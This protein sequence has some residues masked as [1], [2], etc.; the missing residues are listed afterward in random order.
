MKSVWF[1]AWGEISSSTL[2]AVTWAIVLA[3]CAGWS[4]PSPVCLEGATLDRGECVGQQAV[5]HYLPFPE[6]YEARVTQ[7]Y[8]GYETHRDGVA[9]AVDFACDQGDPVVASRDGVVWSVRGDSTT[10]CPDESC[11]GEANYVIIDHGD[12]TFSTYYHLKHR[13]TFVEPGER[14]CQ[15][16]LIGQCGDTGFATG[17]HLHFSVVDARW[18]TI[19]VAFRELEDTTAGVPLPRE[20]YV[21]ENERAP[22]C[23]ETDYSKLSRQAF[24]HRGI[25]LDTEIP[26]VIKPGE[27]QS[28]QVKGRYSGS[29][30]HVAVMRREVGGDGDWMEQCGEVD[31]DGRFAFEIDWPGHVFG[32]SYYFLMIAGS[33]ET[34]TAP[35][36]AWAYRLRVRGGGQP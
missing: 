35:G 15:G 13:G 36:W 1:P 24:L 2:V 29:H 8:H 25:E 17:S 4:A 33:D 23:R 28:M 10:S 12:G 7:A 26:T 19:P 27:Q 20:E 6:G 18:K 32:D 31:D 9:F 21:S 3:G 5:D 22:Y 14:V 30:S 16:Q 34:C 11:I